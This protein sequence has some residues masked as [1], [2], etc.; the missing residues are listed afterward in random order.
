[1]SLREAKLFWVG[2]EFD[3]IQFF[4][5]N[6]RRQFIRRFKMKKSLWLLFLLLSFLQAKKGPKISFKEK[7]YDFGEVLQRETVTHSF[8]FTNEG[9]EDLI[10]KRVRASCGCTAALTT[11]DTIPPG[12]KGE[13]RVTFRTGSFK[14]NQRKKIWVT[15]NDPEK[16]TV[17]LTIKAYVKEIVR[18]E[19]DRIDFGE[20]RWNEK[21]TKEVK[22]VPEVG[23]QV[24]IDSVKLPERLMR[25][26]IKKFKE[27]KKNGYKLLLSFG[28]NLPRGRMN[29]ILT[30]Y[31][32]KPK[33]MI[34]NIP[35]SAIVVGDI[36]ISPQYM[37]FGAIRQGEE[38]TKV[39]DVRA[40]GEEKEFRIVDV[41][42]HKKGIKTEVETVKKGKEYKIK[43][44]LKPPIEKGLLRDS[45]LIRTDL[46]TDSLL[47]VPIYAV[48]TKPMK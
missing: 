26:K 12:G 17:E 19:P 8:V 25:Y 24:K 27:G 47:I 21:V 43:V 16:G 6:K 22:I 33:V 42:A 3:K 48:V 10:I 15:S 46:K 13:I 11:K 45:I 18:I 30:V 4:G 37:N 14:G 32:S 5:Y 34:R 44:T 38:A 31:I 28:P 20:L 23:N 29:F 7:V 40:Q 9:D 35:I 36:V 41:K 39:I 2:I 1:L